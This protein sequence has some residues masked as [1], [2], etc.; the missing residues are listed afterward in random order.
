M[1]VSTMSLHYEQGNVVLVEVPQVPPSARQESASAGEIVLDNWNDTGEHSTVS[2]QYSAVFSIGNRRY[3]EARM[4]TLLKRTGSDPVRVEPGSFKIMH[5][6][7]H[8]MSGHA[9]RVSKLALCV[10]EALGMD[11][12]HLKDL[13]LAALIHDS[14][15]SSISDA[16]MWKSGPLTP[17]EH[18]AM[19]EHAI[20]GARMVE[21]RK[22]IGLRVRDYVLHHHERFDG[23]GYP[24]GL[25]GDKIP[26][27]ARIIAVADAYDALT[28]DR[29]YRDALG[30]REG[31]LELRSR[32]GIQ[33]DAGMVEI[34]IAT[35]GLESKEGK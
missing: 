8:I 12:A 34:L 13:E 31:V 6:A 14:G 7:E 20:A 17:A 1:E 19:S 3:L 21:R 22:D 24:G 35:L 5:R 16:A 25:A 26:I 15:L 23:S 28:T 10:G 4:E 33:F 11:E 29:P 30:H 2:S 9:R 18:Q 32:S 27:G